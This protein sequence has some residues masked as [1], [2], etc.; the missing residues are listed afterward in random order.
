MGLSET[1]RD[2]LAADTTLSA[3]LVGGLY[4]FEQTGRNGL[5]RAT[6]PGA[7]NGFLQPCAVIKAGDVRAVTAIRD[8]EAGVR[9]TVAVFL[10]DDSAYGSI[11]TARDRVLALLDRQWIDGAG[12]VQRVGGADDGRDPKLNN[13]A[14]IRLDFEVVS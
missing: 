11:L 8:S 2:L 1:I 9:Q 3:L 12:F 10:Y 7:F 14:L 6:T 4:S 13:A 5:S